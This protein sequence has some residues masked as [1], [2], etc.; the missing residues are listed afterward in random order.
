MAPTT[1]IGQR[2]K[3]TPYGR[4]EHNS[5]KPLRW[6]ELISEMEGPAY[7]ERVAV[8]DVKHVMRT[9][10]AIK[11]GIEYQRRGLGYSFIEVLSMCPTNWGMTTPQAAEWLKE[12]MI[13]YY[14]LAVFRDR[15]DG[16]EK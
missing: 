2:T 6:C 1:L 12:N 10:K 3:T 13:P 15:G 14:P 4:D 7:I 5:G 11:K 9:K 8:H 16:G